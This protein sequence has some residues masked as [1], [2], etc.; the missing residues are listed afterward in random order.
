MKIQITFT[1]EEIKTAILNTELFTE[2]TNITNTEFYEK[3]KEELVK[4]ITEEYEEH[5]KEFVLGE[6][7][8]EPLSLTSYI[9]ESYYDFY[10]EE[11]FI[12]LFFTE[13]YY[14]EEYNENKEALALTFFMK[15]NKRDYVGYIEQNL[16]NCCVYSLQHPNTINLYEYERVIKAVEVFNNHPL[17]KIFKVNFNNETSIYNLLYS[18]LYLL[19]D[20]CIEKNPEKLNFVV[21]GI[22]KRNR[23]LTFNYFHIWYEKIYMNVNNELNQN[24]INNSY[25]ELIEL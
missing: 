7:E 3:K 12:S 4:L 16:I 10:L 25:N 1:Y 14:L 6:E 2:Y 22:M 8:E 17:G 21:N 20:E 11:P 23:K 9:R 18:V 24:F 13:N 15:D 19:M 5:L